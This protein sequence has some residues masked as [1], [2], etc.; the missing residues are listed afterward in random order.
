[1][2][3]DRLALL[4][5]GANALAPILGQQQLCKRVALFPQGIAQLPDSCAPQQGRTVAVRRPADPGIVLARIEVGASHSGWMER[6]VAAVAPALPESANHMQETNDGKAGDARRRN[7]W[8]AALL[9]AMMLAG[10]AAPGDGKVMGAKPTYL[11]F[12]TDA[13]PNAA[14]LSHR[15][16]TP[17]LDEGYVPQGFTAAGSYLFVSSYKPTPT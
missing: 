6:I 4:P 3:S 9:G 10:C 8:V 13:V 16:Y 5:E 17:A 2:A 14:A 7:A 1:M 15:I 12:F 11:E